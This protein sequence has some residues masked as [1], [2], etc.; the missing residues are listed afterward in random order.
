VGKPAFIVRDA[1]VI[2]AVGAHQL[3]KIFRTAQLRLGHAAYPALWGPA[4]ANFKVAVLD[5]PLYSG[6]ICRRTKIPL[7][8][9]GVLQFLH[10]AMACY[11]NMPNYI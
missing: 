7:L 2:I 4:L 1:N 9:Y 8:R 3:F 6:P 10:A 11:N 5:E